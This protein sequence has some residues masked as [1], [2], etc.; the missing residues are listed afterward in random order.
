MVSPL[1]EASFGYHRYPH[2]TDC[3]L[4]E[5]RLLE[6]QQ[7]L[8]RSRAISRPCILQVIGRGCV[9]FH[10][11]HPRTQANVF[12]LI[13]AGAFIDAACALQE[14]EIPDWKL[15]RM[16]YDDP[17]WYCSFLK[18]PTLPIELQDVAEAAHHSLPLAIFSAFL[19]ARRLTLVAKP[20]TPKSVPQTWSDEHLLCCD[21]F[22]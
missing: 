9:R 19:E 2:E 20:R 5:R 13:E 7:E 4:E 8:R 3:G 17:Y 1:E 6:L 10:A 18:Y 12:R 11:H 15:R 14:L 22:A 21:N 16:I